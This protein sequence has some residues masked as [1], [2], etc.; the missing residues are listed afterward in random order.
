MKTEA[1][2]C[3]EKRGRQPTKPLLQ[4]FPVSGETDES[5]ESNTQARVEPSDALSEWQ[6]LMHPG[7]ASKHRPFR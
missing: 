6:E 4:V 7:S 5:P 3:L 1:V 2:V